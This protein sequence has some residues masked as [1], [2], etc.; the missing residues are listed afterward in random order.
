VERSGGEILLTWNR[1]ADAIRSATQAVLYITDGE[2]HDKV[3]LDLAQLRNGVIS[4]S[5][6]SGDV[7]FKMEVTGKGSEK[8]AS[9]SVRALRQRPSPLAGPE[10]AVPQAAAAAAKGA[11]PVNT[12]PVNVA[13]NPAANAAANPINNGAVP[14]GPNGLPT[15]PE[16]APKT[17]DR[18]LKPFQAPPLAQ[19]LHPASPTDLPDAPS[20][21]RV[22]S[23]SAPTVTGFNMN[24]VSTPIAPAR[25]GTPPPAP[26]APAEKKASGGQLQQAV[27]ITKKDPEYP[28][29][30]RETG[31]KGVVELEATIGTDGRVKSVKVVKGPPMLQKAA[32]DAVMQ[33][34]YRPTMLNGVPVEA[35]TQVLVNFLGG[36]R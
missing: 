6:A 32:S 4:Y 10:A 8:T 29:L 16:E 3:D 23:S 11:A 18:P 26:S 19:R 12:P 28:K 31:A 1:D 14:A 15:V 17:P 27:L 36:E 30:A 9:E 7:V 21:G 5:P 33:W 13:A 24:S 34:K 35:K 22:D 25:P 2:Q 20:V